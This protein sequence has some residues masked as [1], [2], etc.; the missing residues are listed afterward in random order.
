MRMTWPKLPHGLVSNP[1]WLQI[2]DEASS[3]PAVA[4]M[5]YLQA[6]DY[7]SQL[8]YRGWFL[9]GFSPDDAR[10]FLGADP[11]EVARVAGLIADRG[12]VDDDP[13]LI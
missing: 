6:R 13:H 4:C 9:G 11:D 8:R 10:V 12:M 1:V 2:A 3:T 7:A 5:L